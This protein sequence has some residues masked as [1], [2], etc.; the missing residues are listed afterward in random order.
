[1]IMKMYSTFPRSLEIES[2]YQMFFSVQ[3]RA[4]FFV[5]FLFFGEGLAAL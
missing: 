5:L 3:P 1:M 4:P 2:Y